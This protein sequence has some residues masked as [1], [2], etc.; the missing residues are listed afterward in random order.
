VI[1]NAASVVGATFYHQLNLFEYS[2]G[3]GVVAITASNA[4]ALT[5]GSF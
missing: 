4:L 5:V 3:V 2:P 1:P